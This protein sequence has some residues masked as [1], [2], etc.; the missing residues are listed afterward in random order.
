MAH[1]HHHPSH[2]AEEVSA[3][4]RIGWAFFLNLGFT[5]IEFVGGVLTQS[6]AIMAEAIHDLG[7][8]LSIGSAWR[9][10]Q[11]LGC[12]EASWWEHAE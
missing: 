7:D 10:G 5:V 6:T 12:V 8:S 1:L 9:S 3:S 11:W 2:R 4:R